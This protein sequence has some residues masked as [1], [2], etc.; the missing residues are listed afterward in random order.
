M[1]NIRL[2]LRNECKQAAA[3]RSPGNSSRL[4]FPRR[5]GM[6]VTRGY[7]HTNQIPTSS[8]SG[9]L[10]CAKLA[11]KVR[12]SRNRSRSLGD[13]LCNNSP[14]VESQ[15]NTNANEAIN[16]QRHNDCPVPIDRWG[17]VPCKE[18]RSQA[19]DAPKGLIPTGGQPQ[20]DGPDYVG[21]DDATGDDLGY[22][23]SF[24][25]QIHE[26][27]RGL[28]RSVITRIALPP[29]MLAPLE[30]LTNPKIGYTTREKPTKKAKRQIVSN[31]CSLKAI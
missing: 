28:Y 22:G 5:G 26:R 10:G 2:M 29:S 31:G 16:E 15:I 18:W 9:D 14:A 27:P 3:K 6:D 12:I 8:R 17:N 1:Q 24:L 20:T 11:R 13:L 4:T 23:P 19:A 7:A 21:S 25:C 30:Q